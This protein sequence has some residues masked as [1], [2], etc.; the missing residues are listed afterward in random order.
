MLEQIK[1]RKKELFEIKKI[2]EY[3]QEIIKSINNQKNS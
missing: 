1:T 3:S 2:E